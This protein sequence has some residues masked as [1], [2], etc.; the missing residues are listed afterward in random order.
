MRDDVNFLVRQRH[1]ASLNNICLKDNELGQRQYERKGRSSLVPIRLSFNS[2]NAEPSRTSDFFKDMSQLNRDS[3][4]FQ[5]CKI[6]F[7]Q[8]LDFFQSGF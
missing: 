6:D 5:D 2:F 8:M 3:A 4:V 7:G 1:R